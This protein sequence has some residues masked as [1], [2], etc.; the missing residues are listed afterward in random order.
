M[1]DESGALSGVLLNGRYSLRTRIGQGGMAEVYLAD[2]LTLGRP[3]AVKVLRSQF[4]L[5]PEFLTRFQQEGRAAA[6]LSHPGIVSVHDVGSSGLAQYIVMD[7]VDGPDLKAVLKA[8]G[9]LPAAEACDIVIQVLGAL[10]H[11]HQRGLV[12]RDVKPHNILLDADHNARLTD[13]GIARAAGEQQMTSTG[14]VIGTAAYFSPEQATGQPATA[15]SDVYSAGVVLY[16]L[17]TGRPPFDGD[18][19][20]AIALQHVRMEPTPPSRLNPAIPPRLEAVVLRALA[21]DPAARFPTAAIMREQLAS[22][23]QQTAEATT[24][25]DAVAGLAE[26]GGARDARGARRNTRVESRRVDWVAILLGVA[27]FVMVAAA[28][29][30]AARW[31]NVGLPM[32]AGPTSGPSATPRPIAVVTA[33]RPAPS[34]LLVATAP[35]PPPVPTPASARPT[36]T[37]TPG[38]QQAVVPNV[39]GMKVDQARRELDRVG[40]L[41]LVG[42]ERASATIEAGV[43]MAQSP[44]AG[45]SLALNASVSLVLSKGQEKVVVPALTGLTAADARAK[46]ETAGL[47]V[48]TTDD[49]HDQVSAG[50]VFAQKPVAGEQAPRDSVVGVWVSK[51]PRPPTATPATVRPPEGDYAWV[52]NVIGMP[53]AEARRRIELAGLANTYTN[54]QTE[55]DVADKAYFRSIAPGS[56]LSVNP[57][58]GERVAR[59]SV[60]KIAVRKP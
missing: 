54:Y 18:N 14:T 19:P 21:K 34:P 42:E 30:F 2:D 10:H 44:A 15:A 58:V 29:P 36:L 47:K 12:H 39:V 17:L 25:F 23:R 7:Y 31:L 33:T 40:L 53:E 55:N 5:D 59:G 20:V 37:A 26:A 9:R 45:S 32:P 8:R 43:V 52:P 60:A 28:A 11:A 50:K 46:A 27:V 48:E 41:A 35:P 38:P 16:E 24:T 56:V 51:G 49:W 22:V 1:T 57:P 13:F 3:V 4:A 6:R